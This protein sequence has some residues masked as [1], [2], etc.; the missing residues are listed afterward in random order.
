VKEIA[1]YGFNG[2]E[3]DFDGKMAIII[4]PNVKPNNKWLLKTEYFGAFPGLEIE[5][6]KRGWHL[7]F[8][9][10]DNRWAEETDLV[11][12]ANFV[13]FVSKEFGLDEKCVP[14]GM[15]CGGLYA[16]KL[17]SMI[18]QKIQALYLDAPVMNL[19]SCPFGLG[20]KT[21]KGVTGEEY[22]SCTGR[23]KSQML[24]YRD[25]PIDKMPILLKHDIPIVLVAGDSDVV[26]PYEENGQIL[27]Q[28]Y[29]DNGGRIDVFVKKGCDHH[30]HGLEDTALLADIIERF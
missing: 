25:H 3:F 26:V 7:A 15:S 13:N 12:K 24:S 10:N 27:E 20:N 17:A 18:P 30:P 5:L 16:V 19:L 9:Q 11:R 6:L 1:W 22:T 14:V 2:L 28:Y 29:K 8:N 4:K 21:D 23:T